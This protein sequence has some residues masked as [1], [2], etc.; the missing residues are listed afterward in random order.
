MEP[1]L[2]VI[3]MLALGV[4]LGGAVTDELKGGTMEPLTDEL[5]SGKGE[6]GA[7]ELVP[8]DPKLDV[9]LK[10]ALGVTLGGA[11]TEEFEEGVIDA[12]MLAGGVEL[13][14]GKGERGWSEL[15]PVEPRLEV[16]FA[17]ALGVT[18]GGALIDE[19]EDCTIDA[20][21]LAGGVELVGGRGVRGWSESLVPVDLMAT[22]LVGTED[23]T[24]ADGV[25]MPLLPVADEANVLPE[26]VILPTPPVEEMT[27]AGVGAE[28]VGPLIVMFAEPGGMTPEAPIDERM[29]VDPEVERITTP[30]DTVTFGGG[31]GIE[32]GGGISPNPPV[33][34]NTAV[35]APVEKKAEPDEMV[36][37][38][39]SEL[40]G[41][42]APDTPVEVETAVD[43][44]MEMISIPEDVMIVTFT[45]GVS[46][47]R[48]TLD[49]LILRA[50]ADEG[51]GMSPSEP[52][53]LTVAVLLPMVKFAPL[54]VTVSTKVTGPVGVGIGGITPLPPSLTVVAVENETINTV[55]PIDTVSMAPA[56]LE[57]D[58]GGMMPLSP[59]EDAAKVEPDA[60]NPRVTVVVVVVFWTGI[61]DGGLSPSPSVEINVDVDPLTTISVENIVVETD[62][63]GDGGINPSVPVEIKVDVDPLTTISVEIT[64]AVGDGGMRPSLPVEIKVDVDPLTTISVENKA[65]ET[66]PLAA[67]KL[68]VGT[69]P[70]VGGII[71]LSP[72]ETCVAVE[73]NVVTSPLPLVVDAGTNVVPG[74]NSPPSPTTTLVELP[75][76]YV[77]VAPLMMVVTIS[78]I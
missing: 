40:A 78:E 49:V 65:V 64:T 55:E 16:M 51:G 8:V 33:E 24:F 30:D 67:G 77:V 34:L 73:K 3:F 76:M 43:A 20:L 46:V 32:L 44:L 5:V 53:E 74:P 35:D 18:L 29:A 54:T 25:M 2:D 70:V 47:G 60:E 15:L 69:A 62:G 39:N 27:I 22:G 66:I 50:G 45:P 11:V 13:V 28:F 75:E 63:M 57:R 58:P 26:I 61:G 42:I 38:G 7:S 36:T 72:V 37:L 4:T 59:V 71:P 9:T 52:N 12:L 14:S 17:L 6:R 10:L 1:K 48:A 31:A 68:G 19:F 56:E 21:M 41:G 23:E